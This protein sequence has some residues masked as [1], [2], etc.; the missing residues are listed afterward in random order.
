M[1][2]MPP[3]QSVTADSDHSIAAQV[4]A[5]VGFDHF[6]RQAIRI[7]HEVL[8]ASGYLAKAMIAK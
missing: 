6:V 7:G 1:R 5:V 8:E 2:Q 3:P 4:L